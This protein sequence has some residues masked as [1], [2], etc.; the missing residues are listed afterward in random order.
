MQLTAKIAI[1]VSVLSILSGLVYLLVGFSSEG[2]EHDS[3]T[4]LPGI[5]Q[6]AIA[7]SVLVFAVLYV[8]HGS[9]YQNPLVAA[10]AVFAAFI[11]WTLA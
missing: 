3:F 4:L 9:R 6:I 2:S 8:R 7:L 10:M 11:V 5:A 1:V